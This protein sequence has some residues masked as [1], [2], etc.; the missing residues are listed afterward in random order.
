[1]ITVYEL[2]DPS[3]RVSTG[4]LLTRPAPDDWRTWNGFEVIA[5]GRLWRGGFAQAS[6]TTGEAVNHFCTAGLHDDPNL[7]RF[8][9]NST[10]YRNLFKVSGGIPLPFDTMISGLFQVFPGD[11]ILAN[12]RVGAADIGRPF[13]VDTGEGSVDVALI[14]PG[15]QYE[16]FTTSLDLRFSK[17]IT[18]GDVRTRVFMDASN[19][20]NTLTVFARNQ[21]VGGGGTLND[22]FFRPT[23]L[24]AGRVL[25]FGAQMTF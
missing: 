13:N 9:E 4:D 22:D 11:E 3:R 2:T 24:N 20:F 16:D 5:D 12:Y 17:I 8:C 23:S 21:F 18:T 19:L 6:W 10:G 7:L 14:E 25:T 1:M 15:A